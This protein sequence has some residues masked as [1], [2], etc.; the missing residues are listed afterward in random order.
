MLTYY[1]M[2]SFVKDIILRE[3]QQYYQSHVD[4]MGIFVLC[5]VQDFK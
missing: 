4:M 2:Y 3:D 5:V 1:F